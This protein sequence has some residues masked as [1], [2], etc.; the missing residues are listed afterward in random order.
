MYQYICNVFSALHQQI[1]TSVLESGRD[2]A[3]AD[4]SL[5][6]S[7]FYVSDSFFVIMSIKN[8]NN[9]R[10]ST[11][12]LV[13]VLHGNSTDGQVTDGH[14]WL[15]A[16]C[17]LIQL[18]DRPNYKLNISFHC[19][20][21]FYIGIIRRYRSCGLLRVFAFLKIVIIHSSRLQVQSNVSIAL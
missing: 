8:N 7:T 15:L 12:I 20:E 10:L 21:Y 19:Q 14:C 16:F 17:P 18:I 1:Y 9:S 13:N 5:L 2:Q 3:V 4:G 6:Y 11:N